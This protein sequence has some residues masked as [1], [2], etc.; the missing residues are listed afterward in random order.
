MLTASASSRRHRSAG[1]PRFVWLLVSIGAV[2][3]VAAV[4]RTWT[5]TA[6]GSWYADLDKPAWTPPGA[7]FGIVW[8]VLYLMMA[9]A[10]WLVAREGLE[11][12]DV[13]RALLLYA[14]QLALNLGWTA[15][16][17]AA[18]RPGWAI[19]E[20]GALF[21]MVIVTTLSFRPI[22]STAAWLMAPYAAWVAYAASLTIGIA[23]MN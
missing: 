10:A 6:T 13:R 11:R 16:F 2:A 12:T 21:V 20:I 23:V 1:S 5:D 18:E 3:L 22:S 17:F 4:G 7:V 15:T 14:V 8:T 19:V 9:V